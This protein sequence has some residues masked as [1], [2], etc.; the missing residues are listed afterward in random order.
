[1]WLY[2]LLSELNLLNLLNLLKSK[3]K[4]ELILKKPK[5]LLKLSWVEWV[6]WVFTWISWVFFRN[7]I[8]FTQSITRPHTHAHTQNTHATHMDAGVCDCEISM[9]FQWKHV[10][11][12]THANFQHSHLDLFTA[13]RQHMLETGD[14][15]LSPACH[16]R[17][18][19][20]ETWTFDYV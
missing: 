11:N 19:Y 18:K 9:N 16:L 8:N 12:S 17:V 4:T 20:K 13:M 15:V 3:L 7:H 2:M 10:K 6:N 1:M 5:N 14:K